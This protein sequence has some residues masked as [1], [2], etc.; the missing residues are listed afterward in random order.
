MINLQIVDCCGRDLTYENPNIVYNNYDGRFDKNFT[1]SIFGRTKCSDPIYPDK[2]ICINLTG[3]PPYF[4][5][6]L[7]SNWTKSF[8]DELIDVI[9]SKVNEEYRDDMLSNYDIKELKDF[10]GF[11][12][13]Q[14]ELF[15]RLLFRTEEAKKQFVRVVQ[16]PIRVNYKQIFLKYYES[17]LDSVLRFFHIRK[18]QPNGWIYFNEYHYDASNLND[19]NRISKGD[20]EYWMPWTNIF[21]NEKENS[22]GEFARLRILSFDIE[23]MRKEKDGKFPDYNQKED[24]IFQISISCNYHQ[25]KEIYYQALIA[26]EKDSTCNK[27]DIPN[28]TECY[29]VSDE[30][31]LLK[32]FIDL[33]DKLDCDIITGYNIKGFDIEYMYHRSLKNKIYE[34]FS[35]WSRFKDYKCTYNKVLLSSSGLGDNELKMYTDTYGRVLIDA[36]KMFQREKFDSYKLDFIASC[37]FQSPICKINIIEN[38]FLTESIE[39]INVDS[40]IKLVAIEK[41]SGIDWTIG[42]KFK[43]IEIIP[44]DDDKYLVKFT[45]SI[46]PKIINEFMSSEHLFKWCMAKDD[47]T[48]KELFEYYEID[49]YHR[50]I[51]GKYC[52]KDSILVNMLMEK[53]DIVSINIQLANVCKVPLSYIIIR[54]QGIRCYSLVTERCRQYGYIIPSYK[55]KIKENTEYDGALV[56]EPKASLNWNHIHVFDYASLYPSEIIHNNMS[57]ET[58]INIIEG[59]NSKYYNNENYDYLEQQYTEE[60]GSIITCIYA[61]KKTGELGII[62]SIL[63]DLISERSQT[64]KMIKVE[65]DSFRR[66]NL[67]G[68]EKA[69]KITANSIYGQLGAYTSQIYNKPIAACTTSGGKKMLLKAINITETI[70]PELFNNIN[71]LNITDDEKLFITSLLKQY[72]FN[73]IVEYGDT[74]SIFVNYNIIDKLTNE[75]Y[76]SNEGRK[77]G[78]KISFIIEKIINTMLPYPHNIKFEKTYHPFAILCKK[79]YTGI[80]YEPNNSDKGKLDYM[81]IVLV[82]RDNAKIVKKI[83]GSILSLLLFE[84]NINKIKTFVIST[85]DKIILGEYP[86]EYFVTTK[87]LRSTYKDPKRVAHAWLAYRMYERDPASSPRPND[88]ISYVFIKNKENE[89]KKILQG[90]KIEE[91]NYV[92]MN[93]LEI[94]YLHYITNQIMKPAIQFLELILDDPKKEFFDKFIIPKPIRKNKKIKDHDIV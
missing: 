50:S 77:L 51:I 64:K 70:I 55:K 56:L 20:L 25:F 44:Q 31:H 83:C 34:Y 46:E 60:D 19:E 62:P 87:T 6:K 93:N 94:D 54:G 73:P 71:E 67:G 61:R 92:L 79:K 5:I 57:S 75:P 11:R 91:L 74:D 43:I 23:C 40:Y 48:A 36:F 85:L 88:R 49:P 12:A 66:K 39:L 9:K 63:K 28:L 2:T 80:K 86:I 47:L 13:D 42:H 84:N 29:L 81:G 45:P 32:T 35:Q 41:L 65:T 22:N 33:L 78:M 14:N 89:N 53:A 16:R 76:N 59:K 4:Y 17:N 27:Y 37:I 26:I 30:K 38:T 69:L 52:M 68:K 90:E 1:I 18:L 7:E 72:H 15:L 58:L 21:V 24:E 3:F 10:D 82:R 8:L